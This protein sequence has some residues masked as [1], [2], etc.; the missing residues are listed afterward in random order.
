M[1]R[2]S[3]PNLN[4]TEMTDATGPQ[5]LA[6]ATRGPQLN[7]TRSRMYNLADMLATSSRGF[8]AGRFIGRVHP[9][10]WQPEQLAPLAI[11]FGLIGGPVSNRPMALPRIMNSFNPSIAM[12]PR[13]LCPKCKYVV[14]IRVEPLHQCNRSSPLYRDR[15]WKAIQ[16]T[17]YFRGTALAILDTNLQ[18][19]GH[20]WLLSAPKHHIDNR[21][22]SARWTVPY[23]VSDNFAPPWN[24]RLLDIRL[25]N[26]EGRVFATYACKKC[27][28][29]MLIHVH[30][31]VT[32][33]GGV[34][35]L[36][37]FRQTEQAFFTTETWAI[38]RNQAFFAAQRTVGGPQEMLVQPWL[39]LVGSLG[40]LE[41]EQV[42]HPC[43]PD[44]TGRHFC[45]S[46]PRNI[47]LTLDTIKN[48]VINPHY[49]KKELLKPSAYRKQL[50][51]SGSPM[52]GAALAMVANETVEFKQKVDVDTRL[53]PTTNLLRIGQTDGESRCE[54]LLGIGHL[55]RGEGYCLQMEK[56]S[57]GCNRKPT[58]KKMFQIRW[59]F[60]YTQFFYT[61]DP[62]PPF[63]ILAVSSEFCIASAQNPIDCET[64]QC[65]LQSSLALE[66]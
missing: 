18:L 44:A 64:I 15:G 57:M 63:G 29:A 59:G 47:N 42:T 56:R 5:H 1:S 26:F 24:V 12:A 19:L 16:A 6:M 55:H 50:A 61:V 27:L 65:A 39:G 31:D 11:D 49:E 34:K 23:G 46:H 33:D 3:S 51:L 4:D 37:A 48:M 9:Q 20:T 52:F 41:W 21:E 8:V 66:E 62:R 10:V 32:S 13:G 53:S 22:V 35:H 36:R 60:R 17:A 7:Y 14:A 54:A 2:S 25:F 28:G 40:A 58:K 38:G 43:L 45:G 30:G